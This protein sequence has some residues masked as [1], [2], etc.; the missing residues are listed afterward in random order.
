MSS[1]SKIMNNPGRAIA[2]L[3][4]ERVHGLD[5]LRWEEKKMKTEIVKEPKERTDST[6]RRWIQDHE[7]TYDKA[8]S[9]YKEA[10]KSPNKSLIVQYLQD[11]RLGDRYAKRAKKAVTKSRALRIFGVLQNIDL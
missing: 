4:N 11:I 9:K 2:F 3:Y 10:S 5:S 6:G 1:S 8:I 7:E